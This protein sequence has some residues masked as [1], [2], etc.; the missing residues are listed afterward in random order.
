MIML[1][2]VWVLSTNLTDHTS[3]DLIIV[4]KLI[5]GSGEGVCCFTTLLV[6]SVVLPVLPQLASNF[7]SLA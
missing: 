5:L 3:L 6:R 1:L 4:Q 2:I 7:D